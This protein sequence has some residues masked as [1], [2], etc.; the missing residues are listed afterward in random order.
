MEE[1]RESKNKGRV[2]REVLLPPLGYELEK[3]YLHTIRNFFM[4]RQDGGAEQKQ[5][6][7]KSRIGFAPTVR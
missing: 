4:T 5:E 2:E 1:Q 7:R 6:Q 3:S